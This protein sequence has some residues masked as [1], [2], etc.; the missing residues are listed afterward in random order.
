MSRITESSG[1][2]F[3]DLGFSANDAEDL[4]LRSDLLMQLQ[5]RIVALK[6]SQ[7]AVARRLEITQPRVSDLL[8]G[9]IDRF[10]LDTLTVFLRRLGAEVQVVVRESDDL[11]RLLQRLARTTRAATDAAAST[12]RGD[13]TTRIRTQAEESINVPRDACNTQPA[14]AA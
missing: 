11:A 10:S 3:R 5:D 12:W 2:V 1:N 13:A 6:E 4:R 14:I 9:K 7:A 8:R